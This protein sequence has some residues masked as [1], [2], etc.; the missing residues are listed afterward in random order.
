MDLTAKCDVSASSCCRFWSHTVGSATGR[1]VIPSGK[2]I[3]R[4]VEFEVL[5]PTC[6]GDLLE[7]LVEAGLDTHDNQREQ[8]GVW[9][10]L[11][12]SPQR[13]CE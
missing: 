4:I 6:V 5:E 8:R 12:Q 13:L 11:L 7:L 10:V 2:H 9:E 3:G 1:D